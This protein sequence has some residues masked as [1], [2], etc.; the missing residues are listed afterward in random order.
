MYAQ[1]SKNY[2]H[3]IDPQIRNQIQ[4]QVIENKIEFELKLRLNFRILRLCLLSYLDLHVVA[5]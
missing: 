1:K 5:K 3:E 4:T 2:V